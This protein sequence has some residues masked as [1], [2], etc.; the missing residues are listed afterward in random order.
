MKMF[1]EKAILVNRAP[2]DKLLLDF[3]ENGISVLSSENGKG[4]TTI[5]SHIVDAFHEMARPNF[6]NEFEGKENKFYRVSSGIHNLDQ[7]KPSFVY[8]R[9]K[10]PE[11][12]FDYVD[13]RN[14]CTEE[15][16]N[17]AIP[18]ENKI[19]FQELKSGLE[20]SS[21][22]KKVSS[23]FDKKK[24]EEIFSKN[25]ITSFPSYRFEMPGY[26]NDP[27]Q[28]S[29]DFKKKSNFTGRLTNP[30]EVVSGLSPFANW[31]MDIVL[32]L[33][34]DANI[35]NQILFNYL[36]TIITLTLTAKNRGALRFGIG[37]RGFGGT[38]IQI[39]ENK[40]NGKQI[41]PTIFNLSSGEASLLCL[42]G[43]LLRQADNLN[44]NINP[45]EITGIVL[46]DEVDKHLHIKL[47]KEVLPLLLSIFPNVQFILS[48]HSPFLSLGLAEKLQSR[49]KL[50]DI[51][52]GIV[53]Q[54]VH[55]AQYL[56]V[57]EMM[58]QEN[59]KYKS[60]YESILAQIED[61]KELQVITEGKNTEH[62]RKAISVLDNTILNRISIVTGSED[63]S[64]DQ[65]LKN[66]FVI[67]A[68]ADHSNKF[69]FVWDCDSV[70]KANS[71]AESATLF[72]FCFT[73]N[74]DNNKAKKG[75]ENLY[76]EELFTDDIYDE[77]VTEIDYG[78]S[79]K[80]IIFNKGN[81]LTK[82]QEEEGIEVFEN[83]RP[84][85]DKIL[86]ILNPPVLQA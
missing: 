17:E 82:I 72:K 63:K 53:I 83:F 21:Y 31:I 74:I 32:D 24:A 45:H 2:F 27:Y 85:I 48:S 40:D 57:Y 5:L 67:L 81:F 3:D 64:G 62:I 7:S 56:E 78:G 1:L 35:Q 25:I 12:S 79:K 68:N 60:M 11:S 59:Q 44:N 39:L 8:F 4:K 16:Y 84:L 47:Q 23:N 29:L 36:N 9:F 28:V 66:A 14:I 41:Y 76:N 80:E 38:R 61:G 73:Q 43:E 75:I 65:Q 52:R 51:E 50:I 34:M 22:V 58:L 18:I 46:V 54:P 86:A 13:V 55:D 26:L 33:R 37:P 20:S 69:L 42:F 71:V 70:S 30:I 6:P 77:K 49:S 10:L 15:E 19:P